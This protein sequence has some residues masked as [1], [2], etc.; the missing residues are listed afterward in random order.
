MKPVNIGLILALG[1]WG[2]VLVAATTME[3]K[4]NILEEYGFR[5]VYSDSSPFTAIN[6]L[7]ER[8]KGFTCLFLD[9]LQS[10][11]CGFNVQVGD[12]KE[13][14]KDFSKFSELRLL[15][16]Y[17]GSAERIRVSF[18]S[19]LT[20][21]V[22]SGRSKFHEYLL[23]IQEGFFSYEIPF[24]HIEVAAWWASASSDPEEKPFEA[25]R[26]NVI[27]IGFDLEDTLQ[28][29]QHYF[30]VIEFS[31][32]A[33]WIGGGN[34]K[35]WA[36]ASVLYLVIVGLLYNFF[37]L[38]SKLIEHNEEMF[39]LLRKLEKAD[40][41]SAHFKKLSMYDPL[42][43]LLNRRAAL[44]LVEDFSRHNSLAGTALLVMDIDHFKSVNDTHGHDVGDAILK[45]IGGVVKSQL[46]EGDAAVR[47]GGEEVV[48]ICPK[49]SLEGAVRVAEKLCGEIRSR[50]FSEK[51]LPITA[52]FGVAEIMPRESY[53]GAFRRADEALYQA[54]NRGRDRVCK[55]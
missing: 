52:S 50:R 13:R 27:H 33:P 34:G 17:R 14:G 32:V 11:R 20:R 19:A 2:V 21:P 8:E 22:S 42:T 39:G 31:A 51:K 55:A 43:G 47:W 6:W 12:G 9:A 16:A 30:N 38:R 46:R 5:S 37:R 3:R 28:V 26:S 35:W 48:V 24:D 29:G 36:M 44:D 49:T 18:R 54:K 1:L 4:V 7:D 25:D 45:Q 40:T 10:R 41:E 23:P 53:D 15:V